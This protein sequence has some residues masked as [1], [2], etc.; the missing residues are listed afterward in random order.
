MFEFMVAVVVIAVVCGVVFVL[1]GIRLVPNDRVGI[2]EKRFGGGSVAKGLIA[3]GSE[4]GFR[5]DL[6]RGG[7]HWLM[8]IM[9]A[10]HRVPL[11]TIPQ[12]RIGYVFARDGAQL[13]S[14]QVLATNLYERVGDEWLIIHHHGSPVM[15]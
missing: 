4:A 12:G 5:P 1:A 14:E 15:R 11:V 2:V 13:A 3:L 6:L 10:V 7:V 9:Y 8:P